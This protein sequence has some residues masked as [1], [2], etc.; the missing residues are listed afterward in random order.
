MSY[1]VCI[2]LI[3]KGYLK[4]KKGGE[5]DL[6]DFL[7]ALNNKV[8]KQNLKIVVIRN[9][10]ELPGK[11]TGS[12]IDL[13][14]KE[15]DVALWL[16]II[17]RLCNELGLTLIF[18]KGYYYCTKLLIKGV[19]GELELDLNNRFEWRG[20]KFSSTDDLIDNAVQY[21][22]CIYTTNKLMG[23]YITFQH[24]FLYGGF[25]NYRYAEMIELLVKN[26]E[27]FLSEVEKIGGG[28]LSKDIL[29]HM[30]NGTSLT[31]FEVHLIRLKIIGYQLLRKPLNVLQGL[32][33]SFYCDFFK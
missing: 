30:R 23:S 33:M 3:P 10:E 20:I 26:K 2:I 6:R 29:N 9:Y 12:D 5:V 8:K 31:R 4:G 24:S 11:R 21:N 18:T 15:N 16:G 27:W 32:I 1:S 19:D 25:I 17:E 22:D 14:I 13:I 7:Y 28:A